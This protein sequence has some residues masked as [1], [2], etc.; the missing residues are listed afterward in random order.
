MPSIMTEK[1]HDFEVL[2]SEANGYRSR[3]EIVLKSGRA[4]KVGD[5]LGKVTADNADKGKYKLIDNQTPASDGT[6]TAAA[7]LLVDRDATDAD[8]P[9]VAVVRDAEVKQLLLNYAANTTVENKA[10]AM[11]SLA[12]L[13]IIARGA[14]PVDAAAPDLFESGDWS[15]AGGVLKATVTISSLPNAGGAAITDIEYKVDSGEWTSS[16]GI[17]GFEISPLSAGVKAVALRAVNAV[18]IGPASATKNATV[19]SE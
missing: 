7:V 11:A 17:V 18:G 15:I 5:V 8:Q 2:L 4:Y 3:E 19:T 12:A 9:G 10:V 16:E 6:Q 14:I 13:G 1:V